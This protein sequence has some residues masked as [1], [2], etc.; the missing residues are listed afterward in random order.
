MKNDR[1][2][3]KMGEKEFDKWNEAKKRIHYRNVKIL[4]RE[5]EI[6]WCSFGVNVG[7][8][9][10]GKNDLFARPV[11]VFRKFNKDMFWGLPLT[12]KARPN[13][14][15]YFVFTL[16]EEQRTAILSQMRL[17]SSK[18]LIRRLGK[19]SDKQCMLLA[20]AME[21]FINKTDPLRGPRVPNGNK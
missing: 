12:A 14:P 17:L 4:Y 3:S 9:A 19:I 11:I 7:V 8:E 6:W 15:F 5:Q 21:Q 2:K 13:K 18:R 10:D 20:F 16:H 1:E